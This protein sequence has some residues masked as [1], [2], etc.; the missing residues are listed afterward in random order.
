MGRP[1]TTM[2]AYVDESI[3]RWPR[4]VYLVAV[5]IVAP[6][7]NEPARQRLRSVI[8]QRQ[9]R[10]HWRDESR[11]RQM[12]ML[13]AVAELALVA[14]A[15]A[16]MALPRED[17]ARA[18]CVEEMLWDLKELGASRVTFESS[19]DRNDRKDAR[20]IEQAKRAGRAS[21]SLEYEFR[22]PLDKPLLWVSDALAGVASAHV[23]GQDST[24]FHGLPD[25]LL[26]IHRVAR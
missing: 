24:L 16:S 11:P 7:D 9:P 26:T 8:P 3:R 15:Y 20:T 2:H 4:A 25:G 12:A 6:E 1:L 13:D 10:F 23:S 18:L 22:R 17:R 5:A 14:V 19:E 21:P